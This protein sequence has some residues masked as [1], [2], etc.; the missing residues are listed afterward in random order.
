MPNHITNILKLSGEQIEIDKLVAQYSTHYKSEHDR[1]YDERLIYK[2]IG[3]DHGYGWLDEKTKEFQIKGGDTAIGVPEDY[4]PLMTEAW[5]RFPDFNKIIPMP[6]ELNI[7]SGSQGEL[8]QYIINGTGGSTFLGDEE[9]RKRFAGLSEED[10]QKALKVGQ[11]Y[12]D[13]KAKYGHTTWYDW[14]IKNW[15]T[16]WNSYSCKKHDSATEIIFEIQTAWSSVPDMI[17][18]M[19]EKFPTVLIEYVYADEDTGCN[20]G[21]LTYDEGKLSTEVIPENCSIEAYELAFEVI[22]SNKD[23]YEL[24]DG[25]YKYKEDEEDDD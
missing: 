17:G 8:G 19:A 9:L 24:V 12:I 16:K 18:K 25:E 6:E 10:Q 11:Q 2:K 22:P 5:T 15:G 1:G 13:N 21:R 23:Y 14:A 20:C 7:S 4:E 3:T